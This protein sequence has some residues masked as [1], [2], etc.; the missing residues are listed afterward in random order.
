MIGSFLR[1]LGRCRRLAIPYGRGRLLAVLSLILCNGLLQLAGV[2]SVFPFFALAADPERIRNSTFG[3]R[4]I[5]F[6]PPMNT[7]HLLAAFGAFAIIMLLVSSVGSMFSEYLRVRYAYGFSHWL[8]GRLLRSYAGRPYGF[9]LQR[10]TSELLQRVHDIRFFTDEVLLP[11]GEVLTR[12]VL[13]LFLVV[14]I[15]AVQPL[16]AL[17]LVLVLGGFYAVSFAWLR[18]RTR[19]ISRM[20]QED[21][22]GFVKNTSQFLQGIKTVL[23]I[24]RSGH[25]I[26]KAMDHSSRIGSNQAKIP[27]YGNAPR[28]LV[29]PLAFGGLVAVVVVLALRGRPFSDILPNLSVIA[30][31]AF[32][33]LPSLQ[34]VYSQLVKVAAN[35]Y[36]LVQLEEEILDIEE[37]VEAFPE[38][39]FQPKPVTFH[40]EILLDG[41]SFR[42]PSSKSPVFTDLTLSVAKNESLGIAGTSG[43][44]KSTLVDILLGLHTPGSGSVRVDG[45]PVTSLNMEGW[46]ALIGYVPQEIYLLDD[47][48]ASNIA[49][50][51]NPALIDHRALREAAAKA[52][53]LDFIEQELPQGFETVV[54]ERG[55]RLSGGQR[56]RIGLAR[57]LY[58]Q[59]QILIL[60]EATSALDQ[61]M[62]AD[63]M[64]AINGLHGRMTMIIIAHRLG[65]LEQC[66]RILRIGSVAGEEH[67]SEIP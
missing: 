19:G 32:R 65:T 20:L 36:T 61:V 45:V 58:H 22:A 23:V 11:I 12:L 2:T 66:D 40:R 28:Y 33:M 6:L 9:F 49:F 42:Y 30:F 3:S 39:S 14:A 27:V 53:I 48:V 57:A 25:F 46:R 5:S 55:A 62:E 15:F 24:G 34:M 26:G 38:I 52:Q 4:I 43:S 7:N 67:P 8:R 18:P 35:S 54:G 56:Q 13:M 21:Q 16:I 44:G 59:P 41:I 31:A 37:E 47:T 1:L 17:G 51:I 64:R 63:V 60:D 10:N 50:G 29:E